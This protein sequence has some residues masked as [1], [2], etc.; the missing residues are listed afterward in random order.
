MFVRL[1]YCDWSDHIDNEEN[2]C[3]I[4]IHKEGAMITCSV[5][6]MLLQHTVNYFASHK[7]WRCVIL[8][9]TKTQNG[10]VT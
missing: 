8:K 4:D 9:V 6:T 10:T 5:R 2:I 3:T 7:I 1:I